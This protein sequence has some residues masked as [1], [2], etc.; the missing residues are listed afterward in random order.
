MSCSIRRT[1]HF[2]QL[3]ILSLKIVRDVQWDT[4]RYLT[5]I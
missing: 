4:E 3:K 1:T 5:C 2:Q